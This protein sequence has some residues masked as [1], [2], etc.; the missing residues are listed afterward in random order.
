M[1]IVVV[2]GSRTGVLYV[3]Q[4]LEPR[5]EDVVMFTDGKMALDYIRATPEVEVVVT[6]LELT[7]LSG[8]ELCWELRLLANAGRPIYVIAMSAN[9]DAQHLIGVLDAGAD[10][11]MSKP[12][13]ANELSA[14]LRVAE[15]TLRMQ[16]RLIELATIDSLSGLLNRHAFRERA[17][18]AITAMAPE[19][20]TSLI[21]FDIDHFKGINDRLGHSSGDAVI[22]S[23]RTLR[24]PPDT[25]LG[26]IGGEEFA[27][28]LP[29][30]PLDGALSVAEHLRQQIENLVID[31]AGQRI[32]CTA[33]F[34]VA[35]MTYGGS[36]GDLYRRADTA[37]YEAKHTG[38][39]RVCT[40]PPE[41]GRG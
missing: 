34:G 27:L 40:A 10:D 16:R 39:N 1:H 2:D 22:K 7:G 35:T 5:A 12:P 9:A 29:D 37:L 23:I 11:F 41:R 15:R 13:K 24:I 25:F 20:C 19:G 18:V 6:G 8:T 33:S 26:R 30:L 28:M 3:Q 31:T 21:V 17:H 38:R 36:P 14:R 32:S 4:I